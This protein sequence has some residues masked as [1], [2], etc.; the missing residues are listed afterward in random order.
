MKSNIDLDIIESIEYKEAYRQL[1]RQQ[2]ETLK[3]VIEEIEEN[4]DTFFRDDD[5]KNNL[6]HIKYNIDL[7]KKELKAQNTKIY[8][9]KRS[10]AKL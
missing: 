6:F 9:L 7:Q 1:I 5:L 4:Q 10:L 3:N 2:R 8:E